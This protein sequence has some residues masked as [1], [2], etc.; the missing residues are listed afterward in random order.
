[1]WQIQQEINTIAENLSY[2]AGSDQL[3]D[4]F[5]AGV[6]FGLRHVLN[7]ELDKGE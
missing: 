1:M 6:C 2:T 4:K 3:D 7:I 5:K